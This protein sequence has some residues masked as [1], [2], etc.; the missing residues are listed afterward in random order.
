MTNEAAT[1]DRRIAHARVDWGEGAPHSTV[2]GDIYFSGDGPAETAH[3]FLEGNDLPRRFEQAERFSIGELGF[4][5]G[6][7]SLGAAPLPT[8]LRQLQSVMPRRRRRSGP[9]PR[10]ARWWSR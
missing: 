8:Q 2:F 6:L 5:S 4:G 1:N 10:S 9:L 3:V 7:C